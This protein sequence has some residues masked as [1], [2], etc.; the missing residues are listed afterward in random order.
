MAFDR[1]ARRDAA[2]QRHTHPRA[3]P[4]LHELGR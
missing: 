3:L 4:L 1:R 2:Q